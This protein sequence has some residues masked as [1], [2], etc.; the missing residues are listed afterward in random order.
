[1][2][3]I[4]RMMVKKKKMMMITVMMVKKMMMITVMMIKKKMMVKLMMI[5]A[6]ERTLD[7][8]CLQST[9]SADVTTASRPT[10]LSEKG[11]DADDGHNNDSFEIMLGFL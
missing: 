9:S 4:T 8:T 6:A 3:M 2:I 7:S 1:M 5:F 10:T 11:L